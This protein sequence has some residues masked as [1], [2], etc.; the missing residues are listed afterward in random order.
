MTK[1]ITLFIAFLA[2][3]VNSEMPNDYSTSF[4]PIDIADNESLIVTDPLYNLKIEVEKTDDNFNLVFSV[5][6]K[7]ASYYVSPNTKEDYKGKFYMD[8]GSYKD[9][10]FNGK[11]HEKKLEKSPNRPFPKDKD[12]ENNVFGNAIFTQKLTLKNTADFFVYGRIKFVIEP[13]CTM[14]IIPFMIT[15]KDGEMIV[16]EAKC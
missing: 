1:Y 6:L 10:S 15:F 12:S 4:I 3:N 11:L 8:F 13:R 5:D 9:V 14:E 7:K 2:L 16:T